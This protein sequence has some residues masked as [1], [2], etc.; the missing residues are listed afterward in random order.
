MNFDH[1]HDHEGSCG[2]SSLGGTDIVFLA[3]LSFIVEV[4]KRGISKPN[5]VAPFT[6]H[7]AFDQESFNI[8][9]DKQG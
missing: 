9:I 2:V 6:A 8:G 4:R 7:A 5:V 3:M 1:F